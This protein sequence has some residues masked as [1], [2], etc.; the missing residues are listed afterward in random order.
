[1]TEI[2]RQLSEPLNSDLWDRMLTTLIAASGHTLSSSTPSTPS[3]RPSFPP[4]LF[5]KI[6][7]KLYSSFQEADVGNYFYPLFTSTSLS[8]TRARWTFLSL[9]FLRLLAQQ[10]PS[11]PTQPFIIA[12]SIF[13]TFISDEHQLAIWRLLKPTEAFSS[14]AQ[15]FASSL[16]QTSLLPSLSSYWRS[17]PQ[18]ASIL[19]SPTSF[20]LG[21]LLRA[22]LSSSPQKRFEV[23]A[24]LAALL[25]APLPATI[26]T[27]HLLKAFSELLIS[28]EDFFANQLLAQLSNGGELLALTNLTNSLRAALELNFPE[29]A[30]ASL[31]SALSVPLALVPLNP[32]QRLVFPRPPHLT[33]L[34][35]LA[36]RL[37]RSEKIPTL[38]AAPDV[39]LIPS[40]QV[41]WSCHLN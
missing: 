9:R 33:V 41:V 30:L 7:I 19:A 24:Q 21:A 15:G 10:L 4:T 16:L 35:G 37:R 12:L 38:L 40:F 39:R 26:W 13:M 11:L 29:P 6:L 5:V 22:P 36:D 17:S 20:I 25:L 32:S 27:P 31:F 2:S 14:S 18:F 34:L 1:M 23:L 8:P 3:I 28:C